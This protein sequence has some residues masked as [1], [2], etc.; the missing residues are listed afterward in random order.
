[1]IDV[2][3]RV[4]VSSWCWSPII[5]DACNFK[6]G[7]NTHLKVN[8]YFLSTGKQYWADGAR[9]MGLYESEDGLRLR[10]SEAQQMPPANAAVNSDDNAE[11][12]SA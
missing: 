2:I 11:N 6:S 7:Y 4:V 8:H 12:P 3:L 9:A 10:R 5:D 1:V